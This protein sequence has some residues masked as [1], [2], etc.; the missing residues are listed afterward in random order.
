MADILLIGL[1]AAGMAL[2]LRRG[3][4]KKCGGC[5]QNCGS[6]CLDPGETSQDHRDST[7]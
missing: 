4:R 6:A 3:R 2:A 1:I 7:P 5:C